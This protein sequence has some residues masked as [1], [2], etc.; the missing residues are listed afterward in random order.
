MN[1]QSK[2]HLHI[3]SQAYRQARNNPR[4][5]KQDWLQA[6]VDMKHARYHAGLAFDDHKDDKQ[7]LKIIGNILQY[8]KDEYGISR[9]E[10]IKLNKIKRILHPTPKQQRPAPTEYQPGKIGLVKLVNFDSVKT[11]SPL[12][13]HEVLALLDMLPSQYFDMVSLYKIM[14]TGKRMYN[15]EKRRYKV[16]M[17]QAG[18]TNGKLM[19]QLYSTHNWN[20]EQSK[21]LDKQEASRG[22]VL[23]LAMALTTTMLYGEKMLKL[24]KWAKRPY[25]HHIIKLVELYP[26][27][28]AEWSQLPQ[29]SSSEVCLSFQKR[30]M[31]T[32]D[33]LSDY[34]MLAE[35]PSNLQ[36][37]LT[38]FH[39]SFQEY[40]LTPS[41][42]TDEPE[43]YGVIKNLL[44]KIQQISI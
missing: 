7:S 3:S 2:D 5:T 14:Y 17:K 10:S 21:E 16:L 33:E 1:K 25:Q 43:R 39:I 31:D 19:I 35:Q 37:I 13:E 38:D 4:K 11:P 6:I 36:E 15:T 9:S 34:Y 32:F 40:L 20:G 24:W 18:N 41:F 44:S 27:F 26:A 29:A 42:N 12:T 22:I 8:V 23:G 30:N 28:L